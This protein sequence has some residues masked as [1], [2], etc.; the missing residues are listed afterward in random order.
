MAMAGD[1][2]A[3]ITCPA[4]IPPHAFLFGEDQGRYL[5]VT[6]AP[7]MVKQN[8]EKAGVPALILGQTGGDQLTVAGTNAIS[9]AALR[10]INEAWLP[11]FMEG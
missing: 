4:G 1:I 6:S 3:A 7:E 9:I 5:L 11:A 2:G 8:A 10:R